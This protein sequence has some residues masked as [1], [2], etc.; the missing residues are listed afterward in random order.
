MSTLQVP[1]EQRLVLCCVD[2][3]TYVRFT[4]LLGERYLRVNY[5][6]ERMEIMTTSPKHERI[7]HLLG[8]FLVAVT[9]EMDIDMVGLGSMTCRREDVERGLEPDE[10]YWIAH[11]RQVRGRDDLNLERDPPPDLAIEVGVSRSVLDRLSLYASL[12]VPEVWRWDGRTLRVLLLGSDGEY[13]ESPKSAA[14]PFLPVA[15]LARFVNAASTMSDTKVLRSFRAW[16]REQIDSGWTTSAP[17][18]KKRPKRK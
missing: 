15:E 16:V 9:E 18:P 8:L 4:D 17:K 6:G 1:I 7:K 3:P 5:D 2:Y 11:E 12:R 10:C 14:L 13:H